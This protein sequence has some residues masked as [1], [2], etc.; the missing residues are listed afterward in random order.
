MWC[1]ITRC[2]LGG[3]PWPSRPS[4]GPFAQRRRGDPAAD[5]AHHDTFAELETEYITR[6]DPGVDAAEHLQGVVGREGKAGERPCRGERRV[7]PNT[8]SWSSHQRRGGDG[9]TWVR[10]RMFRLLRPT[11]IFVFTLTATKA[12]GWVLKFNPDIVSGA[13]WVAAIALW[14]LVVYIAVV[15]LAPALITWQRRWGHVKIIALL[16]AGVGVI[17]LSRLIF[18]VPIVAPLSYLLG[19]LAVHQLGVAW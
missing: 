1:R 19:W 14:F 2:P 12:L 15:A 17:D 5:V 9:T 3:W 7:A 11:A 6:V 13:V 4:R 8:A 16:V 18:A 10:S